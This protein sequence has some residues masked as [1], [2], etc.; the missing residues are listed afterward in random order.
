MR[1]LRKKAINSGARVASGRRVVAGGGKLRDYVVE[2]GQ[3]IG[4]MVVEKSVPRVR[5]HFDVV[6]DASCDEDRL[7]DPRHLAYP[8]Q[9][10]L[11][12]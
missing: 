6:V 10:S 11:A 2:A 3:I 8:G 5:I 9:R 12:P 4:I 1:C 7:K